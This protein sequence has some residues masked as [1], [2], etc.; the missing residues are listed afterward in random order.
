MRSPETITVT[1]EKLYCDGGDPGFAKGSAGASGPDGH[2]RVFL[3]MN[4]EGF[5]DCPYCG[6]HYVLAADSKA[7]ASGH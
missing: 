6:R 3:T 1:T 7:R 2:P 5:V 4:K